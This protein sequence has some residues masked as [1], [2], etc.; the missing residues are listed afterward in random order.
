[1]C[2]RARERERERESERESERASERER[3]HER[4]RYSPAIDMLLRGR[5]CACVRA[6]VKRAH[7]VVE[8]EKPHGATYRSPRHSRITQSSACDACDGSYKKG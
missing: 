1:M 8:N 4:E 3:E 6:C 7:D 5:V 2:V